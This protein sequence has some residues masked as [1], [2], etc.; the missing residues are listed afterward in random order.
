[1]QLLVILKLGYFNNYQ[2]FYNET[3]FLTLLLT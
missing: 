2:I 3:F 1:M